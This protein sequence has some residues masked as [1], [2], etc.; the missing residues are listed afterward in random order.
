MGSAW[1]RYL[2]P[3]HTQGRFVPGPK[4]AKSLERRKVRVID[5]YMVLAPKLSSMRS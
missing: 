3:L 1:R 4:V 2:L 5:I